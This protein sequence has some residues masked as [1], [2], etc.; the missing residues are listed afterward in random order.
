[1]AKEATVKV[2]VTLNLT[3]L[4][5]PG[6]ILGAKK[7]VDDLNEG[8]I[9]LLVSDCPGTRDDLFAWA[10]T[11]GNRVLKTERMS[12]GATGYYVQRGRAARITPSVVLDMR[13]AVCPGPVIEAKRL[14]SGMQPGEV[15][16]LVSSCPGAPADVREWTKVTGLTLEDVVELGAH[17]VEFYIRKG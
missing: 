6:P 1:M 9:L 2:D 15:L 13:G 10:E 14:L 17:E 12:D 7:V 3:G 4:T 16:K 5:C 11:T 8:Q